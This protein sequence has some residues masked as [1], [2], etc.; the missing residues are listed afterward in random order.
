VFKPHRRLR[1]S[2][3]GPHLK[4]ERIT[5]ASASDKPVAVGADEVGEC[6]KLGAISPSR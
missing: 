5:F 1:I 4:Q 6:G 3:C 2:R